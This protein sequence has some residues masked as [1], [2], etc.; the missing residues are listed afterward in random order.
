M[1]KHQA[2]KLYREK[3][4]ALTENEKIK[5]DDLLL[6]QFQ[7]AA[8]P[9]IDNLLTYWPI[10]ENN[11]P[12]THL[13][14]EFLKFRN[15]EM[16]VCYPVSDFANNTMVAAVSDIDTPFIK[17]E[18]NIFQPQSHHFLPAVEIDMVF[19]PLLSFDKKGFRI[20]YG[21][22]FYDKWLVKCRPNCIKVGFSYFE[23]ME[24]I[25]GLHEFDLPLDLCITPQ[26]TYVF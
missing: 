23:P 19:V 13:F 6:I 15:P 26:N 7:S 14:T 24:A 11:E 20:G 3:R 16:K 8:L 5:L 25:E 22:G 12:D 21:K 17:T 2:R 9:F 4:L 1:Q 18:L 10:E